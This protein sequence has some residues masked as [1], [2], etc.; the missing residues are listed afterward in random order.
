MKIPYHIPS[1]AKPQT[2]YQFHVDNSDLPFPHSCLPHPIHPALRYSPLEF[3]DLPSSPIIPTP[4]ESTPFTFVDNLRKLAYLAV[5]LSEADEFAVDLEHNSFRSYLGI[6]CLMQFSTR[7]ED[8]VVDTFRLRDHICP[9]LREYFVD[10]TK[11]KVMHG[12]SNDVLWLQRD[13]GIY[14]C[15]LFDTMQA[16]K[17]L[18]LDRNSLEFLLR[19]YCRVT[20][21]KEYQTSDWRIRPLPYK[22]VKYAREDT[23]YLLYIQDLMLNQLLDSRDDFGYRLAKVFIQSYEVCVQMYEKPVFSN[24]TSYLHLHGLAEANLDAKQLGVVAVLYRWRDQVAR[25]EDE[26]TGY[27]LPNK[28]LLEIA[29]R[30]PLNKTELLDITGHDKEYV[31]KNVDMLVKLVRYFVENDSASATFEVVAELLRQKMDVSEI[32]QTILLN[33]ERI[34]DHQNSYIR[35]H[36]NRLIVPN[37]VCAKY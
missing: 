17:E 15:N 16:S 18:E 22:M 30:L 27:V 32:A 12:A 8:F 34:Q 36:Q 6:T 33:Q 10:P 19:Y 28:L 11:R 9:Y 14:I 4:L 21:N 7:T 24:L 23:H 3:A 1:L 26:S 25:K 37:S 5:K 20:A 13:F 35:D 2:Q 29:R 31:A